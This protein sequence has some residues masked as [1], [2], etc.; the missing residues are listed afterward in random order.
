MTDSRRRIARQVGLAMLLVVLSISLTG[1]WTKN[2]E[3]A[4][5]AGNEWINDMREQIQSD[6]EDPDKVA[7][8]L[9]V[10]DKIEVTLVELDR[11]V[12]EYYA[13]LAKLDRN[14]NTTREEYQGALDQFN[15]TRHG[16]F[17]NLLS[18]MFEM[19]RIT[20]REDWQKLADIDKTLYESWQRTYQP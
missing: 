4:Y 8:L 7:A 19:K 6:I 10:V 14:Y 11:D 12:K 16:Y 5:G 1:C 17:E 2:K 13:T 9:V 18:N 3:A 15:A 20:G